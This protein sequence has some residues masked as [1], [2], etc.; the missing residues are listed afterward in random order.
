MKPL[1]LVLPLLTLLVVTACDKPSDTAERAG[2][3]MD[4]ATEAALGK[5]TSLEDG[6]MENAGEAVD[7]TARKAGAMA[8]NAADAASDAAADAR[9]ATNLKAKETAAAI[10]KAARDAKNRIE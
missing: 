3:R 5:P 1:T 10:E 2:E 6:P 9:A 4:T 8:D 7:D